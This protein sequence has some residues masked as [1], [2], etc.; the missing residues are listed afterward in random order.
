LYE[1]PFAVDKIR[2]GSRFR[3]MTGSGLRTSVSVCVKAPNLLFIGHVK[4]TFVSSMVDKVS[5]IDC[6]VSSCVSVLKS[7]MSVIVVYQPTFVLLL[8]SI[9]GTVF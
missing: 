9:T 4:I 7:G 8:G 2:I 3:T 5:C 6:T 1:A